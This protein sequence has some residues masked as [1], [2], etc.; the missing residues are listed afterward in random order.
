MCDAA[1]MVNIGI[2]KLYLL[3]EYEFVKNIK[4]WGSDKKKKNHFGP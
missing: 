1:I 3:T 2:G 4:K